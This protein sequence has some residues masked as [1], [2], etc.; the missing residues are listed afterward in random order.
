MLILMAGCASMESGGTAANGTDR[1]GGLAYRTP[2]DVVAEFPNQQ[3]TGVAVSKSGRVFANFRYWSDGHVV[4]VVGLGPNGEQTP[5]PN[6]D[7]NRK[8]AAAAERFVCVQSVYVDDAANLWIVDAGSPKQT[9]VVEA[10][11]G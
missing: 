3:V 6:G 8:T 7:W 2:L 4:S 9:G 10:G 5:Y 1:A 11:E